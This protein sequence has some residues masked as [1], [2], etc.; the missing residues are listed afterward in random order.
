MFLRN[1]GQVGQDTH[2]A[3][4]FGTKAQ[5]DWLRRQGVALPLP[6]HLPFGEAV[7]EVTDFVAQ[8]CLLQIKA[9]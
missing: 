7:G 6:A 1:R 9:I 4:H 5:L 2:F 3:A 8:H